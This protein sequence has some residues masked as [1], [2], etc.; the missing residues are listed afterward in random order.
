MVGGRQPTNVL[1]DRCIAHDLDHEIRPAFDLD[2]GTDS[3]GGRCDRLPAGGHE[4]DPAGV[5]S[6]MHHHH[7][8]GF[9]GQVGGRADHPSPIDEHLAAMALPNKAVDPGRQFRLE[10]AMREQIFGR[11]IDLDPPLDPVDPAQVGK[12]DRPA[13]VSKLA[14]ACADRNGERILEN[15]RRGHGPGCSGVGRQASPNPDLNG[16][17]RRHPTRVTVRTYCDRDRPG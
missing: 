17:S 5:D 11:H 4:P 16:T 6:R 14:E 12:V 9:D 7:D 10:R 1:V 2:E 8:I 15:D 3:A 13:P